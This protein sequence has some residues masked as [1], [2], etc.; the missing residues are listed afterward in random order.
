[1]IPDK[2]ANANLIST[3]DVEEM[4]QKPQIRNVAEP[5]SY[6]VLRLMQARDHWERK[7][8]GHESLLGDKSCEEACQFCHHSREHSV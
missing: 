5:L 6:C 3:S 8:E 4:K 7:T 1:M 2:G